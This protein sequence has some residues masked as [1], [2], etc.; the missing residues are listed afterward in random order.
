VYE[1]P[2]AVR[3]RPLRL[4]GVGRR[5]SGAAAFDSARA[6]RISTSVCRF[7]RG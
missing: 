2:D 3:G 1:L 7:R 6:A 4:D 5:V